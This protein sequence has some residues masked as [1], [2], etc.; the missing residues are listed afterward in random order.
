[1]IFGN[2]KKNYWGKQEVFVISSSR[3][4]RYYIDLGSAWWKWTIG[5][6]FPEN[7]IRWSD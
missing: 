1:L 2:H 7:F 3:P 4:S 6:W 5:Q